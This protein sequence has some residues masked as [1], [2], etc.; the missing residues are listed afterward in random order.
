MDECSHSFLPMAVLPM[1][2]NVCREVLRVVNGGE[3]M[4]IKVMDTDREKNRQVIGHRS[5][6]IGHRSKVIGQRT[7]G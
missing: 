6:I 7:D 4:Q 1:Y 2:L 3:R 5:K